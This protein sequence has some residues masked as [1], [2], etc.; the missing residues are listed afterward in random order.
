MSYVS[1]E[2]VVSEAISLVGDG[3]DKEVLKN[4]ARQWIWRELID[5]PVTDDNIKV[6]DIF[7][8][9]LILKKSGDMR[10]FIEIALYDVN[11]NYLPHVFY[12]GKK[13]IYPDTRIIPAGQ[14]TD[15]N[16]VVVPVD[17]SEDEYGFYIGTNG[18]AVSYAKVRYYSYPLDKDGLPMIREEDV[19][20]M[21]YRVRLNASLKK[22]DNR[23]EIDQN[24]QLY[25]IEAD[26]ARAKRKVSD[27][28]TA[29]MK[30]LGAIMNR[31]IP[32]FNRSNF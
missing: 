10:K 6:C 27:K 24:R 28:S 29:T 1:I 14:N 19:Q 21:V 20:T 8:K 22:N 30:T 2:G 16:P 26:R 5:L 15:N 32:D 18:S 7:A 3:T 12:S 9:N 17:L 11:N 23:S 13:R 25:V 4:F 31:M